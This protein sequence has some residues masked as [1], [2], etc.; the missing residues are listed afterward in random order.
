MKHRNVYFLTIMLSV[1][2][3]AFTAGQSTGAQGARNYDPN[4]EVR[5][6][7][8]V[9]E[10]QEVQQLT[11]GMMCCTGRHLLVETD[12]ETLDVHLGPSSFM[13]QSQFS[14]TNGDEIEVLGSKITM[15]GRETI[16]A[17]EITKQGK[18]LV[19]RDA[20]GVPMWSRARR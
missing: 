7:E 3:L 14:F 19:L 20:R 5:V 2:F 11:R 17:R 10:V 12:T 8:V 13:Q 6:K 9:Q 1:G 18:T 15:A 4:D 16:L